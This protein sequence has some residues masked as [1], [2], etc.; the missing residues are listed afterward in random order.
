MAAGS[1]AVAAWIRDER[2]L[3]LQA[4]ALPFA[5]DD[6]GWLLG[7]HLMH[8]VLDLCEGGVS[9]DPASG[10][11]PEARATLRWLLFAVLGASANGGG[12]SRGASASGD[13][14][15][16]LDV[17][18]DGGCGGGGDGAV[19]GGGGAGGRAAAAALDVLLVEL[20]R[21]SEP[22][23]ALRLLQLLCLSLPASPRAQPLA[24]FTA[25]GDAP[26]RAAASRVAPTLLRLLRSQP[27]GGDARLLALRLL[28]RVLPSCPVRYSRR[29][30][31]RYYAHAT[32]VPC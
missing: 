3:L 10:T 27:M 11:L 14:G 9:G 16:G 21:W 22:L 6:M 25:A 28:A 8:T 7:S 2:R 31:R 20:G 1:A 29:Y 30:S 23:H 18:G 19:V 32:H 26:G 5:A 24:A 15:R 17:D 13:G 4:L 12:G